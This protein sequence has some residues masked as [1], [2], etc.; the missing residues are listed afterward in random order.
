MDEVFVPLVGKLRVSDRDSPRKALETRPLVDI[1]HFFQS[2]LYEGVHRRIDAAD[3]EAGYARDLSDIVATS[4]PC[5]E[6]LEVRLCDG[7]VGSQGEQQGDVDVDPVF[8]ELP[9]RRY[10]LERAGHLDHHVLAADGCPQSPRF[11]DGSLRVVREKRRHFQADEAVSAVGFV[12]HG[13]Q[14]RGCVLDVGDR[15]RLVRCLCVAGA[16]FRNRGKRVLVIRASENRFLENGRI[17]RNPGD[18]A[19]VDELPE[20]T[21]RDEVPSNVIEPDGLAE[22]SQAAQRVRCARGFTAYGVHVRLVSRIPA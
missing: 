8:G 15:E 7:L 14:D 21:A 16:G 3:E 5:F 19:V 20:L 13:L 9:D 17:R 11:F 10:T 18:S 12:V 2:L 22:L 6:T 4:E 1:G